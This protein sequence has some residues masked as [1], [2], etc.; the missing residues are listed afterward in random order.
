MNPTTDR[1]RW[2]YDVD[3]M[4]ERHVVHH[5][6]RILLLA[7]A[8][9]VGMELGC[10]NADV[11]G[12]SCRSD[13]DCYEKCVEGKS[14][15]DGTCTVECVDDFDCP[16]YAACVHDQGGICLPICDHDSDCRDKYTCKDVDREGASGKVPVCIH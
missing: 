4:S 6:P 2:V 15:P 1:C 5:L 13:R 9:I 16:E 3:G 8:A 7:L 14:F 12:G 11:V 10:H